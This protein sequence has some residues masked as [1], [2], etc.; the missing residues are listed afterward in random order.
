MSNEKIRAFKAKT[1]YIDFLRRFI[2]GK[3]EQA[4]NEESLF[5][6]DFLSLYLKSKPNPLLD[7]WKLLYNRNYHSIFVPRVD[8]VRVMSAIRQKKDF[9]AINH[10]IPDVDNE[11][12]V[13]AVALVPLRIKEDAGASVIQAF[14]VIKDKEGEKN[15]YFPGGKIDKGEGPEQALLREVQEELSGIDLTRL[16]DKIYPVFDTVS[17]TPFSSSRRPIS[18]R[19][20]MLFLEGDTGNVRH[21]NKSE[22]KSA[23]WYDVPT[24]MH[25]NNDSTVTH[26]KGVF[27]YSIDFKPLIDYRIGAAE[28]VNFIFHLLAVWQYAIAREFFEIRG[29][30]DTNK[31]A[32]LRLLKRAEG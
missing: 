4:G 31:Y 13:D 11:H 26:D 29:L 19:T 14:V 8:V 1:H 23:F 27:D 6:S 7:V 12:P 18:I 20:Y 28:N 21:N 22:L 25:G 2:E 3:F 15:F 5:F 17:Y 10:L 16:K 30:I 9:R 24:N 32:V